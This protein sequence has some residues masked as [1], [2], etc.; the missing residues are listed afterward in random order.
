MNQIKISL[1]SKKTFTK[2]L[3]LVIAFA[4]L[5]T[6]VSYVAAQSFQQ[7]INELNQENSQRAGQVDDL[8]DEAT[9]LQDKINL[10]QQRIDGI[11]TEI[12]DSEK[13]IARL[14]KEIEEAEIE[15]EKQRSLL[16]SNIRTMYLEGEISTLEMLA[17]SKDLSDY[18][19]KQQY[20]NAVQANINVALLRINDLKAELTDSR[21]NVQAR[22]KQ[23]TELKQEQA[24]KR[25]EVEF[26]LALNEGERSELDSQIKATSKEIEELKRQQ[27]LENIKRYGSSGGQL[28]GGGYPWGNAVCI[29]NGTVQGWC[30]NYDWSFNGSVWNFAT[31]GYGYRNCTD[32][33]SW[34]VRSSG[35]FVPGGLGNAKNWDDRAPAYGYQVSSTPRAGA[36]AVSNYGYYGH[37]MYV[38]AVNGDGS[39]VVSD[40]NRGG[41]GLY[42]TNTISASG[43]SFVYF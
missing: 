27:A 6:P 25:G 22:L 18:V 39:I 7:Q 5:I 32:W 8:A 33:V 41:T 9:S 4:F 40:Y 11:Q 26:L 12:N 30:P 3:T 13:E 21:N 37:V 1:K 42:D 29:H 10:I 20:R 2:T 19:D 38:E 24:S 28:G 14:E 16:G 35:G 17:S 36:A 34:R 43:L 15:L 31:G 23:Q